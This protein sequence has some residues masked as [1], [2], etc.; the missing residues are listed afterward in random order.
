M[1]GLM[2]W[3]TSYRRSF[4]IIFARTCPGKDARLSTQYRRLCNVL[5]NICVQGR[6]KLSAHRGRLI[7]L[8]GFFH[9]FRRNRIVCWS[10][11]SQDFFCAMPFIY[12]LAFHIPTYAMYIFEMPSYLESP[13]YDVDR[14]STIS[15]KKSL[16]A[17]VCSFQLLWTYKQ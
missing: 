11:M 9:I 4:C 15:S 7:S 16:K 12:F 17:G 13:I 6:I 14:Q 10:L 3:V 5:M 8:P 1:A 2:F